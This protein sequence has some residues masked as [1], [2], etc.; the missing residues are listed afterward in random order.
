M[1]K[2][3]WYQERALMIVAKQDVLDKVFILLTI[4]LILVGGAIK[5]VTVDEV[6]CCDTLCAFVIVLEE[7]IRLKYFSCFFDG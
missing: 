7:L 4:L 1:R 2:K 3:N 6:I 5:T